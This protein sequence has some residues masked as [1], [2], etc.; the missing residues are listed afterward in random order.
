MSQ[1]GEIRRFVLDHYVLPARERGQDTIILFAQT[2]L[3]AMGP[4]V[5]VEKICKA[6]DTRLFLDQAI[7]TLIRRQG[8]PQAADAHWTLGVSMRHQR[9]E[10][11]VAVVKRKRDLAIL[12]EEGWYRVPVS[13]AP[14]RW[15]PKWIAFY[16]GAQWG[17]E[18]GINYYAPVKEIHRVLRR[19]LFPDEFPSQKSNK[20]YYQIFLGS[21]QRL[22]P[23]L[24][25]HRRRVIVFIPTTWQ[26]FATAAEINDL[27]DDS[28]LEDS[29][30]AELKRL[31]IPAERQWRV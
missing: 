8:S 30:W 7:V 1:P 26:K 17:Q 12:R 18:R 3:R 14:R 10:V 24:I 11:L 20:P 16:Q 31:A 15:P 22:D 13:T 19:E 5:T 25:S 21:L 4:E 28:P 23:P 6:L 9:G 29:L 27:Y 2:V